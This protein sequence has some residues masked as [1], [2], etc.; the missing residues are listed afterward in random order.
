MQSPRA[1]FPGL[2]NMTNLIFQSADKTVL[3]GKIA[4]PKPQMVRKRRQVKL[5]VNRERFFDTAYGAKGFSSPKTPAAEHRQDD[6]RFRTP[7]DPGP[8]RYELV[9][10]GVIEKMRVT[11]VVNAVKVKTEKISA[12][13]VQALDLAPIQIR[14][15]RQMIVL[16][17]MNELELIAPGINEFRC[18][19]EERRVALQFPL[20]IART[21]ARIINE[22]FLLV[23]NRIEF[24]F[25]AAVCDQDAISGHASIPMGKHVGNGSGRLMREDQI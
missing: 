3:L 23:L 7:S 13:G 9:V 15:E 24:P 10:G 19:A 5:H 20:M 16:G 1:L 18:Q 8:K 17:E 22:E 21:N 14:E 12:F 4:N 6:C 11:R 25:R 2:I